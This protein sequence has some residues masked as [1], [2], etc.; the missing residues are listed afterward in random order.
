MIFDSIENLSLY[1]KDIPSLSTV[2]K[3][4]RNENLLEKK[5]GAYTTE[6]PSCRY[7]ICVY[8]TCEEHKSFEIHKKEM[9]VQII[10]DGSEFMTAAPRDT[11]K[12][13]TVYDNDKDIHFVDGPHNIT[14]TAEPGY[15]AIFLPGEPHAPGLAKEKSI[16]CKK[17]VFK[18]KI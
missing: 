10:L 5:E 1:E 9:D 13:A 14:F 17:V 4:L 2:S 11:I 16:K 8:D 15:F 3:I 18:I 7:N 12:N 6:D